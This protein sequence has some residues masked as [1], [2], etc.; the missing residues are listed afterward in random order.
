MGEGEGGWIESVALTHVYDYVQTRPPV[1]SCCVTQGA[2]PGAPGQ[3]EG[4][5]RAGRWK[6]V[7]EGQDLCLLTADSRCC[8]AETKTTL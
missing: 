7:Q 5:D 1:G 2:Q 6:E 4:R 3:P 8:V